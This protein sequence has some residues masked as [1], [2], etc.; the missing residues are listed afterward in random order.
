M[1]TKLGFVGCALAFN[2]IQLTVT[3][4]IAQVQHMSGLHT[5]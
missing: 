1:H 3:Q 4:L 5:L 2:S